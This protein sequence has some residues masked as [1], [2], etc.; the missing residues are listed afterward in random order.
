MQAMSPTH[1]SVLYISHLHTKNPKV[2]HVLDWAISST[3]S[4]LAALLS[5]ECRRHWLRQ[6]PRWMAT[7]TNMLEHKDGT[8]YVRNMQAMSPI[9]TS[10]LYISHLHTKNTKVNHV[11][12]CFACSYTRS[13]PLTKLSTCIS[14]IYLKLNACKA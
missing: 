6:W 11:P 3:R 5:T 4:Y 7:T 1:M 10:V 14:T 12:Y 2:N 9:H 13:Y 8:I